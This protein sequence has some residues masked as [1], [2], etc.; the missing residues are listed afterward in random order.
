MSDQAAA[1]C[2][3][4]AIAWMVAFVASLWLSPMLMSLFVLLVGAMG[5]FA[6]SE[7]VK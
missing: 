4:L 3:A 1:V 6:M 2:I 7:V 5:M